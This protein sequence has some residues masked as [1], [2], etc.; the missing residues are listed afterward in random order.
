MQ[1]KTQVT[2]HESRV[3]GTEEAKIVQH[4]VFNL[5]E[6]EF[7]VEISEVREIINAEAITPI[8]DSPE[9]ISG[10]I[11]IRGNIIA[12]IDLKARFFLYPKKEAESKHIIITE[13]SYG[14][15]VNEVTE[16]LRLSEAAINEAPEL[17]TKIHGEYIKGVITLENRLI[18]LL[19]FTKVLSEEELV[20]LT[21]VS[22]RE[23]GRRQKAES[24]R[25]KKEG[26]RQKAESDTK[27]APADDAEIV[28][29]EGTDKATAE[30]ADKRIADDAENAAVEGAGSATADKATTKEAKIATAKGV[31]KATAKGVNKATAKGVNKATAEGAEKATT[32]NTAAKTA[33]KSDEGKES[34]PDKSGKSADAKAAIASDEGSPEQSLRKGKQ[35]K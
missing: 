8:P 1:N 5:G 24:R 16:I 32:E 27:N 20:K 15:M 26:R 28:T 3:T 10:I 21:E 13:N 35:E 19:D 7:A 31:N 6:E 29:A 14:I 2:S 33:R 30:E 11:N 18:I 9:F 25:E 17:V 34:S 12:V 4:I 23:E 22:R